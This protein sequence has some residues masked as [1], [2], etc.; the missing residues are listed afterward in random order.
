MTDIPYTDY[1][2]LR[3]WTED[4]RPI[5]HVVVD[6]KADGGDI[7][8]NALRAL[9]AV[10]IGE[11]GRRMG[12]F[13]A[14]LAPPEDSQPDPR[15]LGFLKEHPHAVRALSTGVQRPADAIPAFERFV[16]GLPGLPVLVAA[17]LS[18]TSLW[19]DA[20]LRRFGGHVL[21]RTPAEGAR[22]FAGG[23]IDLSSLVMGVTGRGYRDSLPHLLPSEW[24]AG[25]NETHDPRQDVEMLSAIL[26]TMLSLRARAPR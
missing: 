4:P 1:R 5:V 21:V 26:I 11:Q 24:R 7:R 17:P 22:L 12:D 13:A 8:Q 25:R 23:G 15:T 3:R 16:K 19:L 9:A 20:W 10:A 14:A 2:P 18:Q 6:L